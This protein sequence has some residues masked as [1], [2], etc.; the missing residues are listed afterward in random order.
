MRAMTTEEVQGVNLEV[1][2]K[3]DSFCRE[4]DIRYYLDSGTLLGAARHKG[5]IPWDDDADIVMPRPDYE[6]FVREW[7]DD[8]KYKLYAPELGN[9][10][11]S[12]ARLC[13]MTRTVFKS[14][15]LWTDDT[16]GVG[17]DIFPLDGAPDSAEEFDVLAK[18]LSEM[19]MLLLRLRT[20]ITPGERVVFRKDPYGFAKDAVHWAARLWRRLTFSGGMKKA[21]RRLRD[22]KTKYDYEKSTMCCFIAVTSDRRKYWK[23]EWFD[24]AVELEICGCRFFAPVGY[25]QR[26]AAEYGDWRT[27]PPADAVETHKANQTMFWREK[28]EE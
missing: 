22:I 23:R 17:V 9:C 11:L 12:Y 26:L 15:L 18:K 16:P 28:Q 3:I 6:R 2:R 1:L 8:G 14:V 24:S 10:Y 4:R 13:E 5:F 20:S 25:D 19:R 7:S 27:P 21:L